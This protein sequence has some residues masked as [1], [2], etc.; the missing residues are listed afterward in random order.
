MLRET[1]QR[2]DQTEYKERISDLLE[3][4]AEIPSET[5][6]R[7]PFRDYFIR[8]AEFLLSAG[9]GE[10]GRSLYG[11]I[12]PEHYSRSYGN[13]DYASA[14]LGRDYGPLLSAVYA[15]LRGIIPAF[16][17]NDAEGCAIRLELFLLYYFEFENDPPPEPSVVR[18][19]FCL[20]LRDYLSYYVRR[21][22][23][24]LRTEDT[25]SRPSEREIRVNPQYAADHREDLA[26]VMDER[27]ASMRKR[28][29]REICEELKDE[30][31]WMTGYAS[32]R[33]VKEEMPPLEPAAA[34]VR[35]NREQAEINR[36]L[37]DS[38][39]SI[40]KRYTNMKE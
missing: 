25:G 13:P 37:W 17:E 32:E 23:R 35:M 1:K 24:E 28:M 27:Y 3:R 34:A 36:E 21:D 7:E 31:G 18:E 10:D 30:N 40:L 33:T 19:I 9:H 29:T 2:A 6:V 20:H 8:T 22:I 5:V 14:M 39:R 16:E 15:E 38:V 11:D 4:I 26:L 12:L